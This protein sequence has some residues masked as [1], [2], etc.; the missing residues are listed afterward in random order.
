MKYLGM[1]AGMWALFAAS[2]EKN[3]IAKLNYS[4]SEA[5][6]IRKQAHGKYREIIGKLP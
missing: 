5:A 6:Q 3:L 2:F 4:G 1:P